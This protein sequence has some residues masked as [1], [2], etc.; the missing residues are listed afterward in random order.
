[1]TTTPAH[2]LS[3]PLSTPETRDRLLR[4]VEKRMH[5]FLRQQRERWS[6][7]SVADTLVPIDAVAEL[8]DAGGKRIRPAFC[9]TG[10]LLAGGSPDDPVIVD[11]AA[12]VEF[13][14]AFA[15]I[16]DDVL[17]DSPLRRGTP[18]VHTKYTELHASAGWR[19]ESRRFGEGVAIL[20]GD[21][22]YV[23]A[24]S[25]AAEIPP[26]A[27][28]VWDELRAE[29]IIGQFIDVKAAA[30]FTVDPDLAR[31]IAVCK[32]GRYTIHRPLLLGAA[33]ADRLDL[34]PAFEKYG[35]ALGEAFQLRDDLIDGFGSSRAAGK[36]VGLDF[37]RHK[38]TL[39]LALAL[40]RDDRVRDLVTQEEW[41]SE[42]LSALLIETGVRADVELRIERLV[43][44]ACEAIDRAPVDEAWKAELASMAFQVTHRDR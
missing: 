12:A 30:E 11:A 32:S 5:G 6:A 21:L 9:V 33:I 44:Q 39:L 31:W 16:H 24:D 22:A 42:L 41:D 14:H 43:D 40:R 29:M 15:L 20:A 27:R 26:A 10:F 37:D 4:D 28:A 38:M 35:V 2:E 36:P 25:L 7:D 23:F 18:T 19:G 34:A 1:M 17:D 13:L 8:L 3:P